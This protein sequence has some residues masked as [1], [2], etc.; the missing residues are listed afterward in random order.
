[1]TSPFRV[2]PPL[3]APHRPWRM[4]ERNVYAYRR[5]WYVFLS[6]FLEPVLFLLSI[7][8]GV[9]SLVGSINYGGEMVSY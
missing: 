5:T 3:T 1:M 8:V 6:G 7:G 2:L 4:V 9:G